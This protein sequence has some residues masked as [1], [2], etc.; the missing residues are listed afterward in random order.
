MVS[1]LEM[2]CFVNGLWFGIGKL[3]EWSVVWKWHALWMV[4][5]LEMASFLNG[6]RGMW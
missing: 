6:Q 2:A 5:G 3:Y 1:G 4:C